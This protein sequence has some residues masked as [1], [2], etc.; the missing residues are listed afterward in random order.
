M[1]QAVVRSIVAVVVGYLVF[2]LS[3]F[4]FFQVSGQAPHQV[5]P[6]SVMLASSAFGVVSA[7][8]GGYVAAWLAGRRP[9]RHG[10]AVAVV[11][12]V[13]ALVSLL[14]TFG[15]GAIWSQVAA[16]VLM[17]PSAIFGGWLR[18]KQVGGS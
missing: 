4:A 6:V 11:L 7:L 1:K 15:K 5:A 18:A 3:V 2:A 14:S 13:G 12:A 10:G 8:L 16:L 17:A 9:M